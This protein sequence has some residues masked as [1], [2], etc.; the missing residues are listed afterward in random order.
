MPTSPRLA[1]QNA[2]ALTL[3]PPA[4][5]EI[6]RKGRVDT[7]PPAP[8]HPLERERGSM[9]RGQADPGSILRGQAEGEEEGMKKGGTG[10]L[11]LL[12]VKR[13][14]FGGKEKQ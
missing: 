10:L 9:L 12:I 13:L 3:D 6:M 7:T 14:M 8:H 4:A 5:Q 2:A 1:P 11:V